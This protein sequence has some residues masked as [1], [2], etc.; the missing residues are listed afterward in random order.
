MPSN[1]ALSTSTKKKTLKI[2]EEIIHIP[3]KTNDQE[4]FTQ[5]DLKDPYHPTDIAQSITSIIKKISKEGLVVLRLPANLDDW[6]A[7]IIENSFDAFAKKGLTIGENLIFKIV[8]KKIDNQ[9][10]ISI[11]DNSVG[12]NGKALAERFSVSEIQPEEKKTATSLEAP[13]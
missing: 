1:Q 9:V 10:I 5:R 8:I 12:F 4:E 3:V 11:K 7:E 6:V 13:E 2:F